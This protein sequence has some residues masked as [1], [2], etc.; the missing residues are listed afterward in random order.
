[1]LFSKFNIVI[2]V[3]FGA[4]LI[5]PFVWSRVLVSLKKA[6]TK[7]LQRKEEALIARFAR[8]KRLAKNVLVRARTR[9]KIMD[10]LKIFNQLKQKK[11]ITFKSIRMFE[12]AL[13]AIETQIEKD[14]RTGLFH[15]RAMSFS[16]AQ[17]RKRGY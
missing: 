7:A 11:E 5:T 17:K 6:Y 16:P 13:S 3:V 12:D 15:R 9:T 1:M 10:M 2:I 4:V 8:D 14:V